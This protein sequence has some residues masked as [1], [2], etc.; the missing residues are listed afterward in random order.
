MN[1][2]R[3]SSADRQRGVALITAILVVVIATIA[4]SAMAVSHQISVHR[5][6]TLQE[7][8]MGWWYIEG[9]EQWV[10]TIL[11]RDAETSEHDSLDEPWAQ[12]VD[13]LPVDEGVLRGRLIDLQGRFNINNLASADAEA[14]A[15]YNGHFQRLFVLLG[16][17]AE[18]EA[19]AIASVIRD[20]I[21][22]DQEP[23]GFDGA[24][25]TEYLGFS[26]PYR[27]PDRPMVDIGELMA[28]KGM[29]R[30]LFELLRPHLTALPVVGSA[31]NVNTATEPVLLS[32]V[33]TPGPELSG[34]IE[35]RIEA[36]LQDISAI[37]SSLTVDSPPVGVNSQFFMLESEALIGSSRV[38]LYHLIYRPTGAPP[39]VLA[40]G[41]YPD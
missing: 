9:V 27:T 12:P 35:A 4:A 1:A 26:P 32:L 29:T 18:F 14:Y 13:Y 17:G 2:P 34:F 24:E 21:D 7:S 33:Q 16:A 10:M 3:I 20:W 40:R 31:I 23:T 30:E 19:T 11:Q 15:R 39:S 36:P 22:A 6:Q 41:A 5:A 25:E 28:V 8:E 37:Q 38:G